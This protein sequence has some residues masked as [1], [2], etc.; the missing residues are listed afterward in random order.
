MNVA[1]QHR[2][3]LAELRQLRGKI[4]EDALRLRCIGD[5]IDAHVDHR[6]ARTH[7]A[8]LDH[9]GAADR[10]DHDVGATHDSRQAPRLRVANR[11]RRVGVHQQQGHGL[12]HDVAASHDD[13][14]RSLKW[15]AATSQNFHRS[16]G[17]QATSPAR[18]ETSRPKFA[19]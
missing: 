6:R 8:R 1:N 16:A 9:R 5:A 7:P 14:I 4:R 13:G 12:S 17:V 3:L 2:S 11:Y 19:G 15:N 10:G 18:P